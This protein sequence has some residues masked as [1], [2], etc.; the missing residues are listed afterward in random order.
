MS[1]CFESQVDFQFNWLLFKHFEKELSPK[2]VFPL[3]CYCLCKMINGTGDD[4]Y[5]NYTL[6]LSVA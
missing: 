1:G 4:R 6:T 3:I 2:F 5:V